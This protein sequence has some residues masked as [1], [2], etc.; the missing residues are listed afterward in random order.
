PSR[1]R[2]AY[3]PRRCVGERRR[4]DAAMLPPPSGAAR[5]LRVQC[6]VQNRMLS[7]ILS[8]LI[9][10]PV[11]VQEPAAQSP[12]IVATGRAV[13]KRAPDVAFVTM[14]VESRAKGPRDAQRQNA[15]AIVSVIKRMG[16]LGI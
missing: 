13:V 14:T 12:V 16:E 2:H 6:G 5:H 1:R 4:V 11:A 10:L 3:C 7:M 15:E 9:G 8:A